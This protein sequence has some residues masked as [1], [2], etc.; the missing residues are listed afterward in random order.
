MSYPPASLC[1]LAGWFNPTYAG[2]NFIHPV[3]DYELY[4]RRCHLKD[5]GRRDRERR[6][7]KRKD[8]AGGR[9]RRESKRKDG[10]GG[11]EKGISERTR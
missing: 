5:P 10:A 7:S 1:N 6:E 9:E 4:Q 3:R 8:G 2:V 11:V